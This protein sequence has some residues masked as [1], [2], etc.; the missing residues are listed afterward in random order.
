MTLIKAINLA[1]AVLGMLGTIALYKGSFAF[2]PGG[3]FYDD[4]DYS[5]NKAICARNR[6]RQLKQRIGLALIGGAFALQVAAQ[7]AD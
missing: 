1:S 7:F 4:E 6:R 5:I 2:E 3:G